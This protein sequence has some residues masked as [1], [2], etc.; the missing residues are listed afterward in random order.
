M[1]AHPEFESQFFRH[2]I[3]EGRYRK[4]TAFRFSDFAISQSLTSALFQYSPMDTK[5]TVI[6]HRA[7][8]IFSLRRLG[9]PPAHVTRL[10]YFLILS[11]Y[12]ILFLLFD[13]LRIAGCAPLYNDLYFALDVRPVLD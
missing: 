9:E 1:R 12:F 8:V 3:Q 7:L 10:L 4:I 5:N 13:V 11:N 2:L 6:S